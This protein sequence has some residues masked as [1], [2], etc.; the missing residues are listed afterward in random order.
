[1]G[2]SD[3]KK[4]KESNDPD[5]LTEKEKNKEARKLAKV[6]KYLGYSNEINPFGDSNLLQPFAWGKKKEKDKR[7]GKSSKDEPEKKRIKL[8][9]EIEKV[10]KRRQDREDELA[11]IERLRDEEQ[12]LRELAQ[13]GDW[14]A[15]E[16]EFHLNQTKERSK[17][18][19]VEQR[20]KPIDLIAKNF[21]IIEAATADVKVNRREKIDANLL[22]LEGE[23]RNPISIVESLTEEELGVLVHDL[24]DFLQ[25]ETAREGKHLEFWESLLRFTKMERRKRS[26]DALSTAHQAIVDDVKGLLQGKTVEQ[27]DR[28]QQDIERNEQDSEGGDHEYWRLMLDEVISQRAKSI[29]M[30]THMTLLEQQLTL[31]EQ[32]RST[33]KEHSVPGESS[34]GPK[35]SSEELEARKERKEREAEMGEEEQQMAVGDEVALESGVYWWQDKYRPRKP[36]YFNRVKT[37]WDRTKYNLTHYDYDNPPPKVIQGYKFTLFY[38]DLIDATKTP[39]YFLEPTADEDNDFVILRFHAGPPYEDVAF[40]IINK[41]WDVHRRSGFVSVFE[42]GVLQLNFNFKRVF[43]RR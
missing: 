17:I 4:S 19:L 15:K 42:R 31:L 5:E 33:K 26:W 29:V 2:K 40:K 39:R 41:E 34:L 16:E 1:M 25:L 18:R 28:L 30:K 12:R 8:M 35:I 20:A 23:L 14:Q 22:E 32:F 10:R 13:Y 6:A 37:G 21:L 38:P 9:T 7:E 27:L 11:E 24:D 36:R 3:R 43:Y